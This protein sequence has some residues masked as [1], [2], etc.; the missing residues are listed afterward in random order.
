MSPKTG[1]PIKGSSK[2]NLALQIRMNK[3]EMERLDEC[4]KKMNATRTEAVNAGIQ[5]LKEKLDG[6]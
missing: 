6:K 1:R 4:V 5:L 2:K 3:E